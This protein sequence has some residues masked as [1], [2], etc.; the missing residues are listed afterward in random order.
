VNRARFPRQANR[1]HVAQLANRLRTWM[2]KRH[3][4]C[5]AILLAWRQL[6]GLAVEWQQ[7]REVSACR[8]QLQWRARRARSTAP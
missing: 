2:V 3:D 4:R 7:L 5:L 6:V 8:F 1:L